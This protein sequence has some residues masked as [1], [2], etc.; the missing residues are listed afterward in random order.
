MYVVAVD[1][2]IHPEQI[3]VFMPLMLAQ[4]Q[5]SL[6]KE[7]GCR[8]F[9]VCQSPETPTSIFLYEVYDD[10]AAFEFHT[11]TDHFRSFDAA[12][13]EMV[14]EKQVEFYCRKEDTVS[15]N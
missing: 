14:A 3:E 11:A 12:V 8:V 9:D 13:A 7:P 5:N 6:T 1:F 15:G 10:R 2:R 4:A